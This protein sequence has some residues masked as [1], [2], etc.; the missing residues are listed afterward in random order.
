MSAPKNCAN[1]LFFTENT[2]RHS[3]YYNTTVTVINYS[4]GVKFGL[5]GTIVR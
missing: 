4:L 3:L 1:E 5:K 2:L